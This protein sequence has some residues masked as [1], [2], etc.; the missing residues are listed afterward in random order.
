MSLMHCVSTLIGAAFP[1]LLSRTV[2]EILCI[3]MF[4]GY[5]FYMVYDAICSKDHNVRLPKIIIL[6][7]RWGKEGNWRK[8]VGLFSFSE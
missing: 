4:F 1:L 3:L 2:T 7:K 8:G 6:G 5:G